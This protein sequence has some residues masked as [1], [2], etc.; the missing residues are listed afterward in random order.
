ME[1]RAHELGSS[2]SG[3]FPGYQGKAKKHIS[4]CRPGA[5]VVPAPD[6]GAARTAAMGSPAFSTSRGK[7]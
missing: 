1:G 5:T 3:F 4:I 7:L 6:P 2:T